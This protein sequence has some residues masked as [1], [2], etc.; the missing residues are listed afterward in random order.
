MKLRVAIAVVVLSLG[1]LAAQTF[2]GG[3]QG[4][5]TD[6]TGAAVAG[7]E[8]TATNTGTTLSRTSTSNDQGDYFFNEL[9]LGDY[10]VTASKS[11]FKT[12]AVK[13]VSVEVSA[14]QHVDVK[15]T[16]GEIKETVEVTAQVPLVDTT[17]N[18]M[19]G[20]ISGKMA[21]DL[22]ISGRDFIKLMVFVPGAT[23]DASGVSDSPGTFGQFSINGNRGRAN[24]Y[25]L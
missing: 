7:A 17:S 10:T 6:S 19:G 23:A 3:I 15:L 11:G 8:V 16:P 21:S 4:T 18:V 24:N 20:T 5:V 12:Q 14:S 13:G 22:P 25:L 2:R 1:T 9:P